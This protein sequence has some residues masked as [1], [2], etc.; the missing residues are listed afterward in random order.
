MFPTAKKRKSEK[1]IKLRRKLLCMCIFYVNIKNK[2][3]CVSESKL[4]EET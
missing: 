1:V 2:C 4:S 3:L